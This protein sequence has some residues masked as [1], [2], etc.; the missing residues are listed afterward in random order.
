MCERKYKLDKN[1]LC[2]GMGCDGYAPA[3]PHGTG[4]EWAQVRSGL[5]ADSN[6]PV[7]IA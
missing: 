1:S 6:I 4:P 2:L 3:L 5:E 7:P